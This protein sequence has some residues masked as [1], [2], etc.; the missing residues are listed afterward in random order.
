MALDARENNIVY[1]LCAL[2]KMSIV[3][4]AEIWQVV[5]N[6]M[7]LQDADAVTE[8][9][10]GKDVV[11]RQKTEKVEDFIFFVTCMIDII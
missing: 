5:K 10:T 7:G 3:F 1:I 9:I 2:Q 8:N 4:R 6:W 11:S